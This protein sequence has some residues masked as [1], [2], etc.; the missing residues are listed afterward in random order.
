MLSARV[1]A[2]AD[3]IEVV[4]AG[5]KNSPQAKEMAEA[6]NQRYL[7]YAVVLWR[8][9]ESIK[10]IPFIKLQKPINNQVTAYVCKNF[11]CNQPVTGSQAM[12]DLL[13]DIHEK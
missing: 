2:A 7:P 1:Y 8:D 3:G 9:E 5:D 11:Q 12:M 13:T 6:L 10:L 4:L